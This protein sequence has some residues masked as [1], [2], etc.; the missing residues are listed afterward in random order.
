M[1]EA[2]HVLRLG[3][4]QHRGSPLDITGLEAGFVGVENAG[5]VDQRIGPFGQPIESVLVFEGAT[6]PGQPAV[7][8]HRPPRQR[9]DLLAIALECL[10]QPGADEAGAAGNGNLQSGDH[11]IGSASP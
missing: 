6:H 9:S 2:G 3:G 8:V 5:D 4:C 7:I 11:S 1:D 10:E